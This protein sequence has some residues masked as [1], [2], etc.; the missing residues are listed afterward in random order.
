MEMSTLSSSTELVEV[1]PGLRFTRYALET[2]LP[3]VET[4]LFF[5]KVYDLTAEQLGALLKTLFK[6]DVV[7]ALTSGEHSV[8]LQDY[9]VD[10]ATQLPELREGDVDL[11]PSVPIGE[12]LPHVWQ[13]LEVVVAQSIKD[14]AAKLATVVGS[15]KGRQ[16][17]LMFK[18]MMTLNKKRPTLG[19][20]RARIVRPPRTDNLVILDVSGSMSPG[21]IKSI[22]DDV[23][24]LSYKANAHLA[25]VS[26]TTTMWEPGSYSSQSVLDAAEYGGTQYETLAPVLQQD[27]G[28]V[29]TVADYDS[30][31]SAKESL[32]N[33]C[34]C[35]IEKVI[36]V[37]LVNRPTFLAECVGQF[38]KT[39]QPVL[40][41]PTREV[42]GSGRW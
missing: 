28:T 11:S 38:A 34:A 37:S 4:T 25:I 20:Y 17:E 24:A 22:V 2:V 15:M 9:V 13:D 3:D 19:D 8:H 5:G 14:V 39:V 12:V 29:V 33:S 42:L 10:L 18:S 6:T 7:R 27:W 35:S 16:G 1:K 23:V 30:S 36:D 41:A 21:T 26:Y 32:K 40:I 31:Y